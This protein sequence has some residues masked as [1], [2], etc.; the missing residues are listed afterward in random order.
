[1][2]ICRVQ[3]DRR[4]EVAWR[5]W[6]GSEEA[7]MDPIIIVPSCDRPLNLTWLVT[8]ASQ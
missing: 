2:Y 8:I 6:R 4:V 7:F 5:F 1:M 3:S